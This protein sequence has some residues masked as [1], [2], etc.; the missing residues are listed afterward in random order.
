MFSA[1]KL[2][3]P[4]IPSPFSPAASS[5]SPPAMSHAPLPSSDPDPVPSSPTSTSF[6]SRPTPASASSSRRSAYKTTTSRRHS[7]PAQGAHSRTLF[8]GTP[9]QNLRHALLASRPAASAS[10]NR[11]QRVVPDV[12]NP[13]VEGMYAHGGVVDGVWEENTEEEEA[14]LARRVERDARRKREAI[15]DSWVD[16]WGQ[17]FIQEEEE[18]QQGACACSC[19]LYRIDEANCSYHTRRRA[20]TRVRVRPPRRPSSSL[21]TLHRPPP[22]PA[23]PRQL[24]TSLCSF[25][26]PLLL[27]ASRLCPCLRRDGDGRRCHHGRLAGVLPPPVLAPAAADADIGLRV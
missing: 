10:R 24:S 23:I 18:D 19:A 13:F 12:E 17:S 26:L 3:K 2:N 22:Q 16:E 15:E 8:A 25:S 7:L 1:H 6:Y 5:S 21:P 14:I 20:A 9:P 27:S 4:I 11:P